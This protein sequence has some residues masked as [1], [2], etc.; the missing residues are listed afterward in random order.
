MNLKID[1]KMR[2][3][4]YAL[5]ILLLKE[6]K[7]KIE[8]DVS[9]VEAIGAPLYRANKTR[10]F[11]PDFWDPFNATSKRINN[12]NATY[13]GTPPYYYNGTHYWNGE[14]TLPCVNY[15]NGSNGTNCSFIYGDWYLKG[16]YNESNIKCQV[17][18]M[19]SYGF[20]GYPMANYTTQ[21]NMCPGIEYT[22][23]TEQ[24]FLSAF[25]T[26]E[27]DGVKLKLIHKLN[28]INNTY[29]EFMDSLSNAIS[30]VGL[31]G[32]NISTTNNCK[33]LANSILE[34]RVGEIQNFLQGT[35]RDFFGWYSANFQSIYCTLC[36]GKL[37][38]FFDLTRQ[39]IIYSHGHCKNIVVASL[40]FLL[41][42]HIHFVKITNLIVDFMGS[43]DARGRFLGDFLLFFVL[44]LNCSDK[45]LTFDALENVLEPNWAF[46][47]SW[48]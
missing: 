5:L 40:Q 32:G 37:H 21:I 18:L 23:C 10:N 12:T 9:L 24:D 14:K 7:S 41:Y 44:I 3:F 11:G 2:V 8:K 20:E 45:T 36:D 15:T 19:Q 22:C 47:I 46:R 30:L 33:V 39:R 13:W 43:C 31:I 28:Y 25:H 27:D 4:F 35:I 38:K 34:F 48:F 29:S 16:Y 17:P 42:F 26:W 1:S 6:T